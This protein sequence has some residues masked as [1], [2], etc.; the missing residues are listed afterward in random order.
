MLKR[1]SWNLIAASRLGIG[2]IRR[3]DGSIRSLALVGAGYRSACHRC[4]SKAFRS[5]QTFSAWIGLVPKQHSSVGK[6]RLGSIIC[7][8]GG[9]YLRSLLTADGL[10]V[11][12]HAKIHG[13]KHRPW[14]TLLLT[15]RPTK[16]APACS[17]TSSGRRRGPCGRRA[18]ATRN[19]SYSQLKRNRAEYPA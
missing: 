1:R 5:G 11:I 19:G 17:P 9:R 8:Q 14:L 15:R 3:A 13:T 18:N 12:R 7:K 10:A 2:P 16:V 4:R 6:D